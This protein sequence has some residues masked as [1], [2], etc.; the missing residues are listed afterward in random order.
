MKNLI[1]K[2]LDDGKL[3]L[4]SPLDAFQLVIEQIVFNN[5]L[6]FLEVLGGESVYVGTVGVGAQVCCGFRSEQGGFGGLEL[7]C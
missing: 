2:D 5:Y 3:R 6:V 7:G 4:G 1:E